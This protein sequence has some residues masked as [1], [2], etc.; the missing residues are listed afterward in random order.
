MRT[1]KVCGTRG[2]ER[3]WGPRRSARG[4]GAAGPAWPGV[5]PRYRPLPHCAQVASRTRSRTRSREPAGLAREPGYPGHPGYPRVSSSSPR[6]SRA[7]PSQVAA[8][9]LPAALRGRAPPPPGRHNLTQNDALIL[10]TSS[11]LVFNLTPYRR[12][13]FPLI[14]RLSSTR[15]HTTLSMSSPQSAVR[16]VP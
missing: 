3:G 9:G 2:R 14:S 7:G 10:L 13:P 1:P 12:L 4:R 5:A 8:R 6:F 11:A 15:K 16:S